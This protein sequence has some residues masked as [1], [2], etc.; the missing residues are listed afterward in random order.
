[1]EKLNREFFDKYTALDNLCKQMFNAEKGVSSYIEAMESTSSSKS[2]NIPDWNSD[3]KMLKQYRHMR[4]ELAHS[5]GAFHREVCVTYD[6]TWIEMFYERIK[7][8]KDPLALLFKQSKQK[9]T[10]KTTIG[11][12]KK[13]RKGKLN[14]GVFDT[15]L[16][17]GIAFALILLIVIINFFC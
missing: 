5:T 17:V 1:M 12:K 4:N 11:A 13:K 7:T 8:R 15:K 14:D 9:S 16:I 6:V 10:K 2:R 3:L